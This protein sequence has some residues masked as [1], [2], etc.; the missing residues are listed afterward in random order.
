MITVISFIGYQL[1]II[2]G[3]TVIAEFAEISLHQY[4]F[5]KSDYNQQTHKDLAI[6]ELMNLIIYNMNFSIYF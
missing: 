6:D 1:K 2:V 4:L 5:A 3:I